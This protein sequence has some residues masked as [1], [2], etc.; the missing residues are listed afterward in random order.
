MDSFIFLATLC[1][2]LPIIWKL[3]W[4][5]GWPVWL[6]WWW[7]AEGAFRCSLY[8]SPKVLEVSLCIHHHML[9]HHIGTNRWHHFGWPLGS[10]SLGE[11]SRSLMGSATFEVGLDAISTTDLFDTFTKTLCVRYDNVT[12]VW[13]FIVGRLGIVGAP[14]LNLAG[15]PVESFLHLVQSPFGIFALGESLPEVI[16]FLLEQL[17]IAATME[18]LWESVWITLN[19]AERWWWLSHCRY[20]SVCVGFL[21]TVMDRV[22][23]ASGLTTVSK[24]GMDPSSLLSS[25]VNLMAGSTLLMCWR[26]PCLLASLWMTKVSSTYLH[27]NLGGGGQYLELFVLSTPCKDW[28]QWD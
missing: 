2:S 25:T 8:L 4:L 27:Q 20:W 24:K 23:S 16:V 21:Y 22:P 19:L 28:P 15:R 6:L 7:I 17:R 9:G 3:L 1:P 10:L 26:K 14:I 5:V 12:L 11:T 13:N 18:A